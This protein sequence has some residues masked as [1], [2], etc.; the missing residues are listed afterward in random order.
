MK[1]V[2]HMEWLKDILK[3]AGL[4]ESK[5]DG[6][7]DDSN[8]EIP[9]HM[10]PKSKYNEVAEAKKTLEKDIA[11]RDKQLDELK[12]SV[13]SDEELKKQ[14][15]KLQAENKDAFEK[16]QAKT[17]QMQLDFAVERKL[18]AAKAKNPKTVKALLDMSTVKLDGEQILGL[19]EQLKEIQQS[20]P[21]LFG[22]SSSKVGGGSNPAGGT[23]PKTI[24][25]QI[26]EAIKAG[27]TRLAIKL[28]NQKYFQKE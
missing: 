14:I 28:K 16:W 20:D 22:D 25:Q 15:E 26:E 9:K 19:D 18:A 13:G 5:I 4:E 24:D 8:K 10:I 23:D 27:D 7:V 12:K 17:M 3:K 21:Y 6:V 1:G 2:L 11:E